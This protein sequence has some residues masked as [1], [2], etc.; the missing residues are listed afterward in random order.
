MN[1]R[2]YLTLGDEMHMRM[3]LLEGLDAGHQ[4]YRLAKTH[5]D[6]KDC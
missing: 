2:R 6:G 4:V 5:I 1:R 3:K